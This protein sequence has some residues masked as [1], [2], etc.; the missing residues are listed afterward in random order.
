MSHRVAKFMQRFSATEP[1]PEIRWHE[2][3]RIEAMGTDAFSAFQIWLTFRYSDGSEVQ[4]TIEMRGYWDIVE[5]L[6]TRFPSIS[7]TWYDEMSEQSWHAERV[8]YDKIV[9]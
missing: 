6:H 4:V 3:V 1:C 7:P 9:A 2:V 5:S 8:L